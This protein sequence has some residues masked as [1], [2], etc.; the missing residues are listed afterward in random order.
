ML[1][2]TS[3]GAPQ[4]AQIPQDN[5]SNNANG[6]QAAPGGGQQ[7]QQVTDEQANSAVDQLLNQ[8]NWE[9][10]AAL[11]NLLQK[12]DKAQW[13]RLSTQVQ[14]RMAERMQ[15]KFKV[16]DHEGRGIALAHVARQDPTLAKGLY[17]RVEVGLD[18]QN[19][20]DLA[21]GFYR[22]IG[23]ASMNDMA[24]SADGRA[25]LEKVKTNL[26]DS[27]D[28]VN[29]EE[30]RYVQFL[31]DKLEHVQLGDPAP[32]EPDPT[33]PAGDKP[34]YTDEE[35]TADAIALAK[36][37]WRDGDSFLG[38]RLS[39]S[40]AGTDE[41]TVWKTLEPRT[42][43][44]V[45]Q[46]REAYR[47]EF[48]RDLDAD[49]KDEMSGEDLDHVK[50]LLQGGARADDKAPVR[51][52]DADVVRIHAEVHGA[53][54]S[55]D[56][57][58]QLL[59]KVPYEHRT[60]VA[61]A[62]AKRYGNEEQQKNPSAYLLD[63]FKGEA[64]FNHDAMV[65]AN[66]LF[67]AS[68]PAT[69]AGQKLPMSTGDAEAAAGRL[70]IGLYQAGDWLPFRKDADVDT[71][72]DVLRTHDDAGKLDMI[73]QAY[74]RLYGDKLEDVIK[75]RVDG[76]D[77]DVA[78]S[79]LH[80]PADGKSADAQKGAQDWQA[81]QDATRLYRA[82]DGAG[83]SEGV[84]RST[85]KGKSAEQIDAIAL[86]F[87][88]RYASQDQKNDAG[89][90][91][92]TETARQMMRD[93]LADDLGGAE[94]GEILHLLDAPKS[95]DKEGQ[96]QWQVDHDARRLKLAMDGM[97]TDEN[98]VRE[99]IGG[100][101]KQEI[102]AIAASYE[103]Q[104]GS[105]L[106]NRLT[107]EIGGRDKVELVEHDFDLGARDT[108]DA[109]A[110]ASELLL[111]V[112]QRADVEKEGVVNTLSRWKN[113]SDW[114]TSFQRDAHMVFQWDTNYVSDSDLVDR[115]LALGQEALKGGRFDQALQ[116]GESSQI[117]VENLIANKDAT[118]NLIAEGAVLAVTLPI[119]FLSGGTLTPVEAVIIGAFAGGTTAGTV[120]AALDPQVG[121]NEVMR[122][123]LIGM[124]E[125]GT[126][127]VPLGRAG[128]L[129]KEVT[130]TGRASTKAANLLKG[131]PA[132]S[133][134][135]GT[136]H[137]A[138]TV[139]A[140]KALNA[141]QALSELPNTLGTT[142]K[143]GLTWGTAGGGAYGL[144]DS[145]TQQE[146]WANG[147]GDGLLNVLKNTGTSAA[148]GMGLAVPMSAGFH[149][150]MT[151]FR[152]HAD[153]V[154]AGQAEAAQQA[155]NRTE[156]RA[157]RDGGEPGSGAPV[158][159]DHP[160]GPHSPDT[161]AGAA[162]PN[163]AVPHDGGPALKITIPQPRVAAP[164]RT[165]AR[166]WAPFK[167]DPVAQQQQTMSSLFPLVGDGGVMELGALAAHN[168]N[169]RRNG[170]SPG[171]RAMR[172]S[173]SSGRR[174]T[175]PG[176]LFGE[177]R[178]AQQVTPSGHAPQGTTLDG[179]NVALLDR[180]PA[181][182]AMSGSRG[183][184]P[185]GP[186]GRDEPAGTGPAGFTRV[187]DGGMPP[188]IP[189]G[190]RRGGAAEGGPW[191]LHALRAD[192]IGTGSRYDH[193]FMDLEALNLARERGAL[194]GEVRVDDP[195]AASP[196]AAQAFADLSELPVQLG[197]TRFEPRSR[198]PGARGDDW[199][200]Q[201]DAQIAA[202][203]PGAG[204]AVVQADALP[205][206][207]AST[208][209]VLDELQ[210]LAEH[211]G[212]PISVS[213]RVSF[214][215]D[216][217][218][219]VP[220]PAGVAHDGVWRID[221]WP[222]TPAQREAHANGVRERHAAGDPVQR[223]EV[224]DAAA[225][226]AQLQA[227]AD[228]TGVPVVRDGHVST[229]R[230]WVMRED[231]LADDLPALL[232]Q[233]I[234]ELQA[235]GTAEPAVY[236]DRD[237][238]AL[239]QANERL[240]R[241]ADALDRDFA[242]GTRPWLGEAA[243]ALPPV[244]T[245]R[246]LFTYS[247]AVRGREGV[248]AQREVTLHGPGSLS[249]PELRQM[250][251]EVFKANIPLPDN[252]YHADR[253][254]VRDNPQARDAQERRIAD[255]MRS[256]YLVRVRE[257]VVRDA[258]GV[259][260][261][262]RIVAGA[263]VTPNWRGE[264]GDGQHWL[265]QDVDEGFTYLSHLWS[266]ASRGGRDVTEGGLMAAQR[267]LGQ[268]R[269]GFYTR[270][271]MTPQNQPGAQL[272]YGRSLGGH[273]DTVGPRYPGTPPKG[274]APVPR[275]EISEASFTP[276]ALKYLRALPVTGD[277]TVL[278][279]DK[280][281]AEVRD[282]VL[283]HTDDAALLQ[284][285]RDLPDPVRFAEK[286]PHGVLRVSYDL[287]LLAEGRRFNAAQLDSAV[288]MDSVLPP[289]GTVYMGVN[290]DGRPSRFVDL[291]NAGPPDLNLIPHTPE[292][293][294]LRAAMDDYVHHAPSYMTA[295]HAQSV[296]VIDP[297][298]GGVR[299]SNW[300]VDSEGRPMTP[301]QLADTLRRHGW[302]AAER[303][304]DIAPQEVVL[305]GCVLPDDY[306]QAVSNH[307]GA[308]VY[309]PNDLVAVYR[310]GDRTRLD[311]EALQPEGLQRFDTDASAV[312]VRR[313]TP[314]GDPD[315]P[316]A[317]LVE[318]QAHVP[319]LARSP[320][321][322]TP[323]P[324][325]GDGFL[326]YL[327][328][329]R[330]QGE[331]L[332][333]INR[334]VRHPRT[335]EITG[336]TRTAT[337]HSPGSLT[338]GELEVLA[339]QVFKANEGLPGN[340]Y[341]AGEPGVDVEAKVGEIV[342]ELRQKYVVRV[343]EDGIGKDGQPQQQ[344]I[345]GAALTPDWR[346]EAGD[347][348]H[349]L[350]G[351]L[352]DGYTYLSH[353][354]GNKGGGGD[355]TEAAML[356]A[357]Q[358][359]GQSRFGFYTRW[360]GAQGL[361]GP[362]L[363]GHAPTVEPPAGA[364][365]PRLH[366]TEA[367][368]TPDAASIL[369][370]T[371][372]DQLVNLK[373]DDALVG[374]IARSSS[375]A[376]LQAKLQAL[377]NPERFHGT[378]PHK[379]LRAS[380]E[381][382]L[383]HEGVRL[384]PP[385]DPAVDGGLVSIR[386]NH[387]PFIGPADPRRHLNLLPDTP[388]FAGVQRAADHYA[389]TFDGV[390][391]LGD[392]PAVYLRDP[393]SGAHYTSNW[394]VDK[395]GSVL[396]P[397]ELA[398]R[399]NERSVDGPI[400][401][402]SCRLG[403]DY[404]QALADAT[405]RKVYNPPDVV[406]GFVNGGRL[407]LD[408]G[409]L[410][411]DA[412]GAL[413][414]STDAASIALREF[415]PGKVRETE[416][417]FAQPVTVGEHAGLVPTLT[418]PH[419]QHRPPVYRGDGFQGYWGTF[420]PAHPQARI[421]ELGRAY[422]Q[423][424]LAADVGDPAHM[425]TPGHRLSGWQDISAHGAALARYGLTQA[426]L[427]PPG[428]GFVARLYEPAADHAGPPMK[429]QLVFRGTA[430]GL[431]REDWSNNLRHVAGQPS[432]Y[433]GHAVQIGQKLAASGADVELVGHS[434]GGGLASAA[435]LVSGRPA[436]TF[437]A[438]GLN[439]RVRSSLSDGGT[440][441]HENVTINA[442]HVEGEVLTG[443]QRRSP[444]ARAEGESN[445]VPG[446][447]QRLDGPLG[448]LPVVEPV[449]RHL[450]GSMLTGLHGM[451]Q[452][453]TARA[454]PWPA[455]QAPVYAAGHAP[456]SGPYSRFGGTPADMTTQLDRLLADPQ[457][458]VSEISALAREALLIRDVAAHA[459]GDAALPLF[460]RDRRKLH[461]EFEQRF[462]DGTAVADRPQG[463]AQLGVQAGQVAE[464]LRNELGIDLRMHDGYAADVL[465]RKAAPAA[466]PTATPAPQGSPLARAA[467]PFK[468]GAERMRT[469]AIA[470][471]FDPALAMREM[472]LTLRNAA[473]TT[474]RN[475]GSWTWGPLAVIAATATQ[476]P[477][478]LSG[479]F[480][481]S[482]ALANRGRTG[483]VN[484]GSASWARMRENA[485]RGVMNGESFDQAAVHL[486]RIAGWRGQAMGLTRA[487]VRADVVQLRERLHTV[488]EARQ[489]LTRLEKTEAPDSQTLGDARKALEDARDVYRKP[490]ESRTMAFNHVI[491]NP[492]RN[493]SLAVSTATIIAFANMPSFGAGYGPMGMLERVLLMA[494][495][496]ALLGVQ[497][498]YMFAQARSL[499]DQLNPAKKAAETAAFWRQAWPYPAVIAGD[500]TTG[501]MGLTSGHYTEGLAY[502]ARAGLNTALWRLVMKRGQ[503]LPRNEL[504]PGQSVPWWHKAPVL[505]EVLHPTN[506]LDPAFKHWATVAVIGG[507]LAAS[508]T[509]YF[510]HPKAQGGAEP[511][512]PPPEPQPGDGPAEV[513]STQPT[514]TTQPT[515]PTQ[516]TQPE[517]T[518]PAPHKPPTV[519]V[520]SESESLWQIAS[521]HR[522]TLLTD[523]HRHR[524]ATEGLGHSA[525]TVLALGELIRLNRP[526]HGL[527]P[528][529][530]DGVPSARRGDPDTLHQGMRLV[531]GRV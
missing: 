124:A 337:L 450:I 401:I 379:V 419:L 441:L 237:A 190:A 465:A 243:P 403:D 433:Y 192:D 111:R 269:F 127:G 430:R 52:V 497:G 272:L 522:D 504:L 213:H 313:F 448:R 128:A 392:A 148:F 91:P 182:D 250:A 516:P 210:G 258:D 293:A 274:P 369:R 339:R 131:T 368:F 364:R 256:L 106:R 312:P 149:G 396:S 301:K 310:H 158:R 414:T 438:S 494:P 117:H 420:D 440:A 110:S 65:R 172:T 487:T 80:K 1:V 517:P 451:L 223:I 449:R 266:G 399:L 211:H 358:H 51:N 227:L 314:Q 506:K 24:R 385:R 37:T 224:S 276:D 503:R 393:V 289:P 239:P 530:L 455:G 477:G 23:S 382:E 231:L 133:A 29:D 114:M 418:A 331:T 156:P 157:L 3:S 512:P 394:L 233:R 12:N 491:G 333:F 139:A 174:E 113:G 283:R 426:D 57:V 391:V 64:G 479:S 496:A 501:V 284:A 526:T 296:N 523:E 112:Q 514:Q 509:A 383:L 203:P 341:G 300:A 282:L 44:E 116:Y 145:A 248:T 165:P 404:L 524:I 188:R 463:L 170:V 429:P 53:F 107:D 363:G 521:R 436:T 39:G 92:S 146:T 257:T 287:K 519:T 63:Q 323:A 160:T 166:V 264:A 244:D 187:A 176:A 60:A 444:L 123:A 324:R 99:V 303:H 177:G 32:K 220:T 361:Y 56:R 108:R 334:E 200:T 10:V 28:E 194:P 325:S 308:T 484:G 343:R 371:P 93:R 33:A 241:A 489:E 178:H 473:K 42:T 387:E 5:Q 48:N 528:A 318:P 251:D 378:V 447:A 307:L 271:S 340:H 388:E 205:A 356:A 35:A 245:P 167:P 397:F 141:R 2:Y 330:P 102:E 196:A 76:A 208:P 40:G 21:R 510:A 525:Q 43:Q 306:M 493:L 195:R 193:L 197:A 462:V 422:Q 432:P 336:A 464:R 375:D 332:V 290:R 202:L 143:D 459:R 16:E 125:G 345:A 502:L 147:F 425:N 49:M 214:E 75:D 54:G 58:L 254:E 279:L 467:A 499:A 11:S 79:L 240:A 81:D 275:L 221:D 247:D 488:H 372:A 360:Q 428:S 400:V 140:N 163:A 130:V 100:K 299:S 238:L 421:D 321:D 183:P 474:V 14:Q 78:L 329:E 186:V 260:E 498:H 152:R 77:L 185:A 518:E 481:Q 74:Q 443:L 389:P 230:V 219:F 273:P 278:S 101:S 4:L 439:P 22:G 513:P 415:R 366:I 390:Q 120:Y 338:D 155:A 348:Q 500:V 280:M 184:G 492:V 417:N 34:A 189:P 347:G 259:V 15:Q 198:L 309:N 255:E 344:L 411:P 453:T 84:L 212:R 437:D 458:H 405:G 472:L 380:Y 398:R 83:T 94:K 17:E 253:P 138:A 7:P 319:T 320:I 27:S 302:D 346:G 461:G 268:S 406:A 446:P 409:R 96:F 69:S 171:A 355:V 19:R 82:V 342:D 242:I 90:K 304:A 118:T 26:G 435:A 47:K 95:T 505:G 73:S 468:A 460:S 206:R 359:L 164:G 45:Q 181:G 66:G 265:G 262:E 413:P 386:A 169:R 431:A 217:R 470:A 225:T 423:A 6:S 61:D 281:P 168:G 410:E 67:A 327:G 122:H 159:A 297:A 475:V 454:T 121:S 105:D 476:G 480:F 351:E 70:H 229:P 246:V 222:A 175:G 72:H 424:R 294:D 277:K 162:R 381:T 402:L 483:A 252:H 179:G 442:Y 291:E 85:L 395:D 270:W 161:A 62:Y 104:F 311:V 207:W 235:R 59:E 326:G 142:L 495:S 285:L 511:A 286:L 103:K 365:A 89:P 46:I 226:P 352:P 317:T 209:A 8:Q 507:L 204:S 377:P 353:L 150:L 295:L 482:M 215:G 322:E 154:K 357:Q 445:L 407:R 132:D 354:W 18:K 485:L 490:L 515:E 376:E 191:T 292:F 71:V 529:L 55:D 298:S 263:A 350:G 144:V 469:L 416:A 267:E 362:Q 412:Q 41:D 68:A 374:L 38:M 236:I 180:A 153:R 228:R 218:V 288:P 434:L 427:Q 50:A 30:K 456:Q 370:A 452:H 201:L 20:D 316:F 486:D 31:D 249:E 97:G 126:A 234:Q 457:A 328:G 315:A 87:F 36:A 109:E 471:Q 261:S 408:L 335:N 520:A 134:V 86:R 199:A 137:E 373:T 508:A 135:Y 151:P 384:Y 232:R 88:D 115:N 478:F 9:G 367:S 98:L 216:A 119:V 527:D 136:R 25:L 173:A 349:W 129:A 13:Q 531:V 305:M 466:T